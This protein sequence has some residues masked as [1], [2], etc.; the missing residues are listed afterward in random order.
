MVLDKTRVTP[1]EV[2]SESLDDS[3]HGLRVSPHPRLSVAH[4][5]GIGNQSD[6]MG[7]A[8]DFRIN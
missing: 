2:I 5:P 7:S 3:L 6:V 8:D 4:E 1:D